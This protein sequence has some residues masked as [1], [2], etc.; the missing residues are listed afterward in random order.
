MPTNAYPCCNHS[1]QMKL[2]CINE[3]SMVEGNSR[4]SPLFSL[5]KAK[6]EAAKKPIELSIQM[7]WQFQFPSSGLLHS[8]DEQV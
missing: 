6:K 8:T 7:F 3:T 4:C 2:D 1:W 5:H